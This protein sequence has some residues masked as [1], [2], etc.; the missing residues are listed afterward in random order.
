MTNDVKPRRRYDSSRRRQQAADTRSD[1][2]DAAL[3]LFARDGWT[4]T[5]MAAIAREAGVSKETLYAV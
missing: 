1:V 4:T 5:T 3:K 2:L